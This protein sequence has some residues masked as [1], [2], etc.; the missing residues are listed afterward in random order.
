[1]SPHPLVHFNN[2]CAYSLLLQLEEER[3]ASFAVRE[4]KL[5]G[6]HA[7]EIGAVSVLLFSV[8]AVNFLFPATEVMGALRS[9]CSC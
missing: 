7:T 2:N 4:A 9:D 1:L 3:L 6:H 5:R 8:Q